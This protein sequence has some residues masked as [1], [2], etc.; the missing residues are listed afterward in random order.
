MKVSDSHIKSRWQTKKKNTHPS[1]KNAHPSE[2]KLREREIH[3]A[4]KVE[5][6]TKN[7]IGIVSIS[8]ETLQQEINADLRT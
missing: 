5:R 4:T 2:K 3:F 8:K 6:Q 7:P 1:K